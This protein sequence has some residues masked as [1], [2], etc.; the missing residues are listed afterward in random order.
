MSKKRSDTNFLIQGTILAAAS[1]ISRVIG[2]VYR[3]P[4]TAIIG[5][6]GNDYYSCAYEIYSL[7]LLISGYSL[8]MAV[9]KLVS[10]Q[11]SRGH[12]R[13]VRRV[14]R[15][16]L[17]IAAITG[18][19][20]CLFVFFGAEFL[21]NMFQTP[22]SF[23]ALRVLAPTLI[24]VAVLGV[25]RGFFQGFGTMMP[26][27]VSQIIEQIVN[28]VV[29]VGAAYILIGYG[30]RVASVLGSKQHYAEAF[31]AA[32]GTLGTSLGAAVALVFVVFVFFAF[33]PVMNRMI[34]REEKHAGIKTDSYLSIVRVLVLTIVPIL[35]S[36]TIYNLVSIVDQGLFKN[37]AVIQGYPQSRI[38]E[39]WGIFSGKY[40]VLINVPISISTALATSSMPSL[41]AAFAKKDMAQVRRKIGLSL[42]FVMIVSIPCTVGL[43]VLARPIMDLLFSGS[44]EESNALA[45]QLLCAG[46]VCIVFYAI[47]TLSNAVLQGINRMLL[48]VRN[49]LIALGAHAVV[50]AVVMFAFHINIFGVSVGVIVFSF[51]MSVLNGLSVQRHSGFRPNIVRTFIKPTAA[52]LVMG[53]VVCILYRIVD[54]IT[55]SN[56]VSTLV[57]V[58]AG[59]CTYSVVLLLIRGIT[60]TELRSFPKGALLIKI[61]KRL[62][63]L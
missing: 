17:M 40:R 42:R 13:N 6:I 20:G 29:S 28:A 3:L 47:S 7:L 2:L 25:F 36:T 49:A 1:I 53:G 38:S 52:S 61:A 30:R 55:R 23:I 32:G 46:G 44:T 12:R 59:V 5:D 41:A 21:T 34:R 39:W 37:L 10:V 56:A 4:M 14:F 33:R 35:L 54:R 48:P 51:L 24:I 60:E 45:G 62:R 63:L 50:M 31:G 58:L 9:S 16:A 43:I 15:G 19:A 26:S 22:L 27:A 11:M 18:T 8:P 57:A